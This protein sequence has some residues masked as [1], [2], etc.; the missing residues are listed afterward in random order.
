M[1]LLVDPVQRRK[2]GS[3]DPLT[4]AVRSLP[5][6]SLRVGHW[7]CN[8]IANGNL[9]AHPAMLTNRLVALHFNWILSSDM[10]R[11]CMKQN[12]FWMLNAGGRRRMCAKG[13]LAFSKETTAKADRTGRITC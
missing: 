10:K 4:R 5:D 11:K 6:N 13:K 7:A 12:R 9:L 1:Q 3:A 8:V 2:G